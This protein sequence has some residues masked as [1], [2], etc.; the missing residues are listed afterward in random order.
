MRYLCN[1]IKSLVNL[2]VDIC[3]FIAA[4]YY[5]FSNPN[6][7]THPIWDAI[8]YIIVSIIVAACIDSMCDYVLSKKY[9]ESIDTSDF[10]AS[11]EL[12]GKILKFQHDKEKEEDNKEE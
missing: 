4:M 1:A 12:V 7:K 10:E 5:Y 11:K 3:F 2:A 6:F 9:G 8:L